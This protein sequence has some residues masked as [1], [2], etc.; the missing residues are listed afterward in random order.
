M[1]PSFTLGFLSFFDNTP[2]EVICNALANV[3]W[4]LCFHSLSL[5]T[6]SFT[7]I[8]TQSGCCLR[9]CPHEKFSPLFCGA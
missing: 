3:F 6:P 4:R 5:S 9:R 2:F 7:A 8:C 1:Y